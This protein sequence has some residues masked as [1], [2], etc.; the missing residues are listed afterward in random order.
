MNTTIA[1]TPAPKGGGFAVSVPTEAIK[2]KTQLLAAANFIKQVKT[3]DDQKRAIEVVSHIKALT[4]SVE[5]ARVEVKAPYLA[6]CKAIDAKA[7]EY[8]AELIAE[9]SALEK[10]IGRFQS[11]ERARVEAEE[12][13]QEEE[14]RAAAAAVERAA[15]AAAETARAAAEAEERRAAAVQAA[16]AATG[17]AAKKKATAAA[18]EAERQAEEAAQ[19][20]LQAEIDAAE[21]AETASE[22]NAIIYT[23]AAPKA[24]GAAVREVLEFEVTDPDAF[25]AWDIQR[26]AGKGSLRS[27]VKIEVKRQDFKEFIN[28][29]PAAALAEIPGVTF[30]HSTKAAVRAATVPETAENFKYSLPQ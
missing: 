13:R 12:R 17:A 29:L 8:N 4:A 7:K 30:S 2:Q 10:M 23:P 14:R 27:F 11:E 28:V 25:A 16:A 6:A 18:A 3:P 9:S 21:A 26:R 15:Q 24:H 19:A 22:A 5:A 1:I 20:A